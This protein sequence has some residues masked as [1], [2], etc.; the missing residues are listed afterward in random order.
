MSMA[1]TKLISTSEISKHNS[2]GDCW[3]VVD[4]QVWD[5]TGFAPDHPGGPGI[6][7][8]HAG[9][10]ATAAYAAIHAPSI[11]KEGLP[12]SALKG[13]LDESTITELWR[14][15]LA[16]EAPK[17]ESE[18]PPLHMLINAHDFELAA[19]ATATPKTWAFYSSAATDLIT[20][21]ANASI[22]SHIWFRPRTMCNVTSCS[23]KSS[24]LGHPVSFPLMIAPAAMAKLIHPDGELAMARA[25]A[26]KGIIQV[27]STNASFSALEIAAQAPSHPF[28]FQLYVNRDR[29]AT[30]K[31]LAKLES[32]SNIKAIFVTV[33]AAAAGKREADER[34]SADESL[35]SG[36]GDKAKND[37]K[38]GGYGRI[39]GVSSSRRHAGAVRCADENFAEYPVFL[40][41]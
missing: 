5:I 7:Y 20:R 8:K 39:M 37:K 25:A 12:E 6:I 3:I 21:D 33:D 10:D 31:L 30:E 23:T 41:P 22:Y 17:A 26:A 29:G 11:I 28:F 18:K 16:D 38:G 2:D 4:N 13:T 34:V 9:R 36:Y 27:I 15:P 19:K 40:F 24:I 1:Q 14:K 32:A 35:Q